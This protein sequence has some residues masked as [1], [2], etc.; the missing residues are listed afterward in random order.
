MIYYSENFISTIVSS[1]NIVFRSSF[2][3]IR[4]VLNSLNDF[5]RAFMI[6]VLLLERLSRCGSVSVYVAWA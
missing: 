3:C 4:T 6:S 5:S 2:S 1:F